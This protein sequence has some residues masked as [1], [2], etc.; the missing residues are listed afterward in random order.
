MLGQDAEGNPYRVGWPAG[1]P[2][3]AVGTIRFDDTKKPNGYFSSMGWMRLPMDPALLQMQP[4]L[5]SLNS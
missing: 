1:V 2:V 5:I 3:P 4:Y